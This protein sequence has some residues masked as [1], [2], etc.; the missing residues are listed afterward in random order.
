MTSRKQVLMD[1]ALSGAISGEVI[2]LL[3]RY[4]GREPTQ[5][6]TFVHDNL[7]FCLLGDT[8][9]EAEQSLVTGG[10]YASLLDTRSLFQHTM[11]ADLTEAVERLS[12]RRVIAFMSQTHVDPDFGVEAFVLEPVEALP[13]ARATVYPPAA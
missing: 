10:D 11:R 7:I 3:H 8:V 13:N 2:S 4:T 1:G 9:T 5:A 12:G 6:R